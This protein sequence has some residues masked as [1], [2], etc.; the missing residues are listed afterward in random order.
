MIWTPEPEPRHGDHRVRRHFAW[1]PVTLVTGD[2]LWL[3]RYYA[4]ELYRREPDPSLVRGFQR[5]LD[6]IMPAPS[7]GAGGA[8]AELAQ[9]FHEA[10]ERLAPSFGYTTREASA[11]PWADVPEPNRRLMTAVCGEVLASLRARLTE[12]ETDRTRIAAMVREAW[13]Q[14]PSDHHSWTPLEEEFDLL[15]TRGLTQEPT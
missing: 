15:G 3:E 11:K 12:A 7:A 2:C 1:W 4:T 6:R 10:Y 5:K 9:Q 8:A 13:L 14:R